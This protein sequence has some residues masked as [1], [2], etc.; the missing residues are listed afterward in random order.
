ME[1]KNLVWNENRSKRCN[2][3]YYLKILEDWL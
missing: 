1:L 3:P 2:H